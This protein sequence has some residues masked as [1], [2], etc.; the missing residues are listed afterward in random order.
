[1]V[2]RFGTTTPA[3]SVQKDIISIPKASVAKCKGLAN[4]SILNR[5]SAKNVM[6]DST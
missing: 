3:L 6:R 5:A 2:V 4:N 1:L